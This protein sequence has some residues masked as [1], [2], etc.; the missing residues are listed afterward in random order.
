MSF[1]LVRLI[2]SLCPFFFFFFFYSTVEERW[3]YFKCITCLLCLFVIAVLLNVSSLLCL[4]LSHPHQHAAKALLALAP[5]R[6]RTSLRM[7]WKRR[8]WSRRLTLWRHRCV[9]TPSDCLEPPRT[10]QPTLWREPW[11]SSQ[12][13]WERSRRTWR[14]SIKCCVLFSLS[15]FHWLLDLSWQSSAARKRLIKQRTFSLD[16]LTANQN[17]YCFNFNRFLVPLI[18]NCLLLAS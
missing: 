3:D 9:T 2:D 16:L 15:G 4:C 11:P 5:K 1:M 10:A 13:R 12:R 17:T 8:S 6:W 7:S 18:C 14:V